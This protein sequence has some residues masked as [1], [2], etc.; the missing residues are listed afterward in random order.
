MEKPTTNGRN[1]FAHLIRYLILGGG[2]LFMAYKI[3]DADTA[4]PWRVKEALQKSVEAGDLSDPT[5]NATLQSLQTS[6]AFFFASIRQRSLY[7]FVKANGAKV[8]PFNRVAAAVT[9]QAA[10]SAPGEGQLITVGGFTIS[11]TALSPEE[12]TSLVIANEELVRLSGEA[13]IAEELRKAVIQATDSRLIA[14][15]IADS[16]TTAVSGSANPLTDLGAAVAA[17]NPK[18]GQRVVAAVPTELA[19]KMAWKPSVA[20]S[21]EPAYP[22]VSPTSIGELQGITIFPTDAITDSP[23]DPVVFIADN[24]AVSDSVPTIHATNQATVD[25]SGN[26]T[27]H[28]SLWQRNGVGVKVHR[29]IAAALAQTGSAVTITNP[30]W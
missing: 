20:N 30:T 11:P 24:L 26:D 3:A 17:L 18:A 10:A 28:H 27:Q 6:L 1:E 4:A 19:T 8:I 29:S 22:G 25:V 7:E 9:V 12:V 23:P 13:I 15:L 5:F 16:S 14:A 2:D 21:A